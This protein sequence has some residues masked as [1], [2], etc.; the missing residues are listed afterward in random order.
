MERVVTHVNVVVQPERLEPRSELLEEVP[1]SLLRKPTAPKQLVQ[2]SSS[3]VLENEVQPLRGL[4][5]GEKKVADTSGL[6]FASVD[7][8]FAAA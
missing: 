1:S 8:S 7:G 3:Q 5:E 2:I 6:Y 4:R